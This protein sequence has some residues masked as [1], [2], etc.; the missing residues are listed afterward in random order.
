MS[1]NFLTLP[2]ELRQEILIK[3]YDATAR[4]VYSRV[5]DHITAIEGWRQA[6]HNIFPSTAIWQDIEYARGH[7][8][9]DLEQIGRMVPPL[10]L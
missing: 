1:I 10:P 4:D 6:P 5:V 7:W 8:L 3:S 9:K 2:A